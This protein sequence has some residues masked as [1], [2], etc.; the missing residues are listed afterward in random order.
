MLPN[1]EIQAA[2]IWRLKNAASVTAVVPE[3]EI[4]EDQWQGTEFT[5]P[6]VRVALGVQSP[7]G[8][9]NCQISI[10]PVSVM[11]FTE[12]TSSMN[13]DKITS[14]VND[15]LHGSKFSHGNVRFA[16]ILSRGLVGAIRQDE[17]TWRGESLFQAIVEKA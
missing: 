6:N 11:I 14:V 13:C 5:Y 12:D 8:D 16:S 10:I 3:V 17:R 4:R 1:N 15:L 9:V 2:L 7:I